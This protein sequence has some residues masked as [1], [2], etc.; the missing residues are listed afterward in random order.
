VQRSPARE[1]ERAAHLAE[2]ARL[3][4]L[5]LRSRSDRFLGQP[6]REIGGGK[7]QG[8]RRRWQRTRGRSAHEQRGGKEK[9]P[10][11][12]GSEQKSQELEALGQDR[13]GA[14]MAPG[15]TVELEGETV[16]H[17]NLVQAEGTK[18]V[19]HLEDGAGGASE[20]AHDGDARALAHLLEARLVA[21]A[22]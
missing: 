6:L 19:G 18:R 3:L 5:T 1:H 22:G 4:R 2:I 14:G 16:S 9:G 10:P 7:R 20:R 15:A 8:E 13:E 21:R 12:T 11:R 17:A